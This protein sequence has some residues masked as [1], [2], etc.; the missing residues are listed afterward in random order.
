MIPYL[1]YPSDPP[2]AQPS[3]SGKAAQNNYMGSLGDT[4]VQSHENYVNNR[5]AFG[6]FNG[7]KSL[8]NAAKSCRT[9]YFTIFKIIKGERTTATTA[10]NQRPFFSAFHYRQAI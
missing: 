9:P 2:S 3:Y 4:T 10:G 7:G 6:V 8:G 1:C 5:G